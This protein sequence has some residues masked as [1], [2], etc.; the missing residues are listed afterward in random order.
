MDSVGGQAFVKV[1]VEVVDEE[2]GGEQGEDLWSTCPWENG[3]EARGFLMCHLHDLA[4]ALAA[5]GTGGEVERRDEPCH[6]TWAGNKQ[7][8]AY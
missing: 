3:D 1:V 8:N 4:E 2:E 5:E 7:K 6:S